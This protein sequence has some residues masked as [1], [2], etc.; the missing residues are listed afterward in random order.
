[1][2]GKNIIRAALQ[3]RRSN[4]AAIAQSVDCGVEAL[5]AYARGEAALS[6]GVLKALAKELF[7]GAYDDA[8]D[9]VLLTGGAPPHT[10]HGAKR[11]SMH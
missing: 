1:M 9:V 11:E 4:L 8:S 6:S 3:R 5:S 7:N 2:N 10:S